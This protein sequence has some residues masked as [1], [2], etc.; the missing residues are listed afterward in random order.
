LVVALNRLFALVNAQASSQQRFV[1]D[2]AHQLRTPLAALQAQVEAWAQAANHGGQADWRDRAVHSGKAVVVRAPVDITVSAVQVN[3]LRAAVRRTSQLANQLLALSRVEATQAH[4]PMQRVDLAQLCEVVFLQYLDAAS[5]KGIDLGMDCQPSHA[6]GQEWLLR[7]L[8][9]NLVDNALKY[10]PPT[11]T[12][13]VRCGVRAPTGAGHG[14]AFVQVEDNG[15]G[16][17]P[18]HYPRVLEPFYRMAGVAGEG[19]GLGLAIAQEIA[20]VHG[21]RLELA[22][23]AQGRGLRV[24]VELARICHENLPINHGRSP[25][26]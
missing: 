13:T 18:P 11:G 7:E 25:T 5:A 2:A 9:G 21:S 14:H 10:T 26:F 23:A 22:P 16:I 4:G 12:V 1:A 15:P 19:S 24:T 20:L 3:A 17:P 8:L 6:N